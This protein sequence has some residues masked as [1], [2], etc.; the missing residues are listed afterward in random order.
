MKFSD[1]SIRAK[2]VTG[3][4]ILLAAS[5][6]GLIAGGIALMYQT[7]GSEAQARAKAL[8]ASYSQMAAV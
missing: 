1:L 8:L 5:M 6:A 2:L 7:A 4:G 3:A